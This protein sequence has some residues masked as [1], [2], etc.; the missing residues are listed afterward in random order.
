MCLQCS[1]PAWLYFVRL[2]ENRTIGRWS[3]GELLSTVRLAFFWLLRQSGVRR[4]LP[5][6][7]I[8]YTR[9]GSFL[10]VVIS[11]NHFF[12]CVFVRLRHVREQHYCW[13]NFVCVC[14]ARYY[15]SRG[16]VLSAFLCVCRGGGAP[17]PQLV[18]RNRSPVPHLT[19]TSS[20]SSSRTTAMS[21]TAL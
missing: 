8:H 18:D 20:S 4:T 19:G 21:S 2:H 15:T 17:G 10:S 5:R 9:Y 16:L 3:K 1:T 13:T 12:W 14:P 7:G 6:E 11:H